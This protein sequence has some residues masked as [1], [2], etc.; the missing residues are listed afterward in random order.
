MNREQMIAWLALEGWVPVKGGTVQSVMR[1]E[2]RIHSSGA[3]IKESTWA[4]DSKAR[5]QVHQ[6]SWEELTNVE[7]YYETARVL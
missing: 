3:K 5:K 4:T 6:I 7:A 1:G 2:V